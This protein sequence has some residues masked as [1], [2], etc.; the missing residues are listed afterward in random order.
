VGLVP[1][2]FR[3]LLFHVVQIVWGSFYAASNDLGSLS[4]LKNVI[5]ITRAAGVFPA[6]Y[7]LYSSSRFSDGGERGEG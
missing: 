6:D 5:R 7:T 4:H 3:D 1:E 2:E